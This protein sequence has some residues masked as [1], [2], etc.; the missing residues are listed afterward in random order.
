MMA[1]LYS[2]LTALWFLWTN[3]SV[4]IHNAANEFA[5]F[6]MDNSFGKW[7][8]TYY[9]FKIRKGFTWF[10]FDENK[11]NFEWFASLLRSIEIA[12]YLHLCSVLRVLQWHQRVLIA[13]ASSFQALATPW[14]DWHT[15]PRLHAD[16][17]P[18]PDKMNFDCLKLLYCEFEMCEVM[19]MSVVNLQ[20]PVIKQIPVM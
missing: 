5:S 11:Q 15:W 18:M 3:Q 7:P 8:F 6:C 12:Y 17:D 19:I 20:I 1:V 16:I 10:V 4:L 9:F 2:S 14:I 13:D